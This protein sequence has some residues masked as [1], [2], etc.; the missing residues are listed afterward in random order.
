METTR[1]VVNV[2]CIVLTV[3]IVLGIAVFV[4]AGGAELLNQVDRV[5]GLGSMM[6]P[7]NCA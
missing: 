6:S 2:V 7:A 3:L 4:V 5:D 1:K